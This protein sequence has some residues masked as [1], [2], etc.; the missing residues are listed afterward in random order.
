MI[1]RNSQIPVLTDLTVQKSF[2]HIA[3]RLLFCFADWVWAIFSQCSAY[4]K[5]SLM[6]QQTFDIIYSI[7]W[8]VPNFLGQ[9][10]KNFVDFKKMIPRNSQI[11]VLTD[12][13]VQKSFFHI[14]MR[15][16]FC[17]A[18]WV[19]AI[20]SQCSAYTKCSSMYQQTFD[21]IYSIMWRVPK[22]LG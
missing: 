4:K 15:L 22:V 10:K 3:T 11:P 19:W 9:E 21:I 6:Y 8:H 1:P 18:D 2:F 13:T 12:L 7:M 16:P 17:L 14:V 20:F 5:C